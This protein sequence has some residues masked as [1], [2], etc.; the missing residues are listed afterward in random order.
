MWSMQFVSLNMY[1]QSSLRGCFWM[2]YIYD[3][4]IRNNEQL[5]EQ[6]AETWVKEETKNCLYITGLSGTGKS[7][8]S[9]LL[10]T[11]KDSS[12]VVIH[13][14]KFILNGTGDT[15]IEDWYN[16]EGIKHKTTNWYGKEIYKTDVYFSFFL[17]FFTYMNEKIK[18]DSDTLYIV[19]G[20]QFFYIECIAYIKECGLVFPIIVM[21]EN[22]VQMLKNLIDRNEETIN[23]NK[24]TEIESL[25]RNYIEWNSTNHNNFLALE[26]VIKENTD[27]A[28]I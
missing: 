1:I 2:N 6:L 22:R 24:V 16:G 19:E 8:L 27:Y 25:I 10:N 4:G 13:M 11:W 28:E 18:A 9:E 12:C 7:T 23:R 20:I 21:K 26:A 17:E 3:I 5:K 15:F 14:D